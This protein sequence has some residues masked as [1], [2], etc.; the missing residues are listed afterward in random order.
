M[1]VRFQLIHD[2]EFIPPLFLFLFPLHRFRFCFSPAGSG[3]IAIIAVTLW[4]R[5]KMSR[6]NDK[7]KQLVIVLLVISTAYV[8]LELPG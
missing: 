7:D 4:R 8:L 5:S 6:L 3:N 2:Y 1:F